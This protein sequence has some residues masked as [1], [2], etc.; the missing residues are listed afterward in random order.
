MTSS[1]ASHFKIS[2]FKFLPLC[3]IARN[4]AI[5]IDGLDLF[6]NEILQKSFKNRC[7]SKIFVYIIM[8]RKSKKAV[9]H[10]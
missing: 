4:E 7:N 8:I 2:D 1:N 6:R 3:V 5:Q 9:M 10:Q